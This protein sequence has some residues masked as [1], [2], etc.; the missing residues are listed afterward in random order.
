MQGLYSSLTVSFKAKKVDH[1]QQF[2]GQ[3][4][5]GQVEEAVAETHGGHQTANRDWGNEAESRTGK[6]NK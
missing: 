2:W 1:V 4:G 3:Q 5:H 6:R